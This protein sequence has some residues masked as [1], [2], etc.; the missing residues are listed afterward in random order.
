MARTNAA[1]LMAD[2]LAGGKL[3]EEISHYRKLKAPWQSIASHL[4]A[5]FGVEV[6]GDT[7]R[8]WAREM[9]VD[10]ASLQAEAAS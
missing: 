9:G 5:E 6:T 1:R 10:D 3:A 7:L 2:R 8:I 4:H